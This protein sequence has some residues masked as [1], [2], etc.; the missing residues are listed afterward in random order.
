ML[1]YE[2]YLLKISLEKIRHLYPEMEPIQKSIYGNSL[3]AWVNRIKNYYKRFNLKLSGPLYKRSSLNYKLLLSAQAKY[4]QFAETQFIINTY[5]HSH[6][7]PYLFVLA[8]LSA[9]FFLIYSL[10]IFFKLIELSIEGYRNK[11]KKSSTF[12]I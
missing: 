7:N 6:D 11:K 3:S 5:Q 1:V 9:F 4:D 10:A 12:F 8:S 2:F